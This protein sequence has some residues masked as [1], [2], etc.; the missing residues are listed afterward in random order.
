MFIKFW[1]FIVFQWTL[2]I[3]LWSPT[4]AQ[5]STF[6]LDLEAQGVAEKTQ[7]KTQ[8]CYKLRKPLQQDEAKWWLFSREACPFPFYM[9]F[10]CILWSPNDNTVVILLKAIIDS[11]ISPMNVCCKIPV[12]T[13]KGEKASENSKNNNNKKLDETTTEKLPETLDPA[14]VQPG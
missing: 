10:W 9:V 14:D 7:A 11:L 5:V 1:F 6:S 4:L 12:E 13:S 3:M 2:S 8:T